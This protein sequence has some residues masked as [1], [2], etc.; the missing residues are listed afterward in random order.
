MAFLLGA[1]SELADSV[2]NVEQKISVNYAL[3]FVDMWEKFPTI[4]CACILYLGVIPLD[5]SSFGN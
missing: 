2:C 4:S 5:R 1:P 3:Q